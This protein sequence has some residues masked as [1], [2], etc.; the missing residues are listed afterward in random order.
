MT[1]TLTRVV[2]F[3]T[4]GED[5]LEIQQLLNQG[6]SAMPPLV[7]DGIFGTKSA[8]RTREFQQTSHLVVDGIVGPNTWAELLAKLGDILGI[9]PVKTP[10]KDAIRK[11]VIWEASRLI[12]K[13]DFTQMIDGRPK[14]IDL[15]QTMFKDAANVSLTDANFRNPTTK[16][17]SSQPYVSGKKKSWCGIFCIYCLRQAGL[18][19]IRW[20]ITIGAP[21][22][23]IALNTWST[24]FVQNIK[25]ADVGTVATQQHHFL[26]EKVDP[27][28]AYTPSL[29]T[30][31]GNLI[32]GRIQRRI[33]YHKVGKDNF[34]Y[35]SLK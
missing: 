11:L 19:S 31:D 6:P 15:I 3:G 8:S 22:G 10:N 30:I 14:G 17:W 16:A 2:R 27:N 33:G 23:P 9:P 24:Q 4:R 32:A 5:A 7:T 25:L 29:H 34:N 18:K 1:T 26:I 12:G 13:V 21:R 28:N 20:D 35:Y